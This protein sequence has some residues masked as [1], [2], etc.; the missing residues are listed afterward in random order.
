M[1]Y[2]QN[3]SHVGNHLFL[4]FNCMTVNGPKSWVFEN[5]V[6]R[7]IF[8]TSMGCDAAMLALSIAVAVL[9]NPALLK[10]PSN[11]ERRLWLM[12]AGSV[13]FLILQIEPFSFNFF[14]AS[15]FKVIWWSTDL[16]PIFVLFYCRP[17]LIGKFLTTETT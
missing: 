1:M 3:F 14:P 6:A 15:M 17:T 7:L 8:R 4:A 12:Y 16:L 11:V 5:S 13:L 10:V 9:C 2:A